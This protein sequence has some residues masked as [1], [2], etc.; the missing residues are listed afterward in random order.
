MRRTGAAPGS[1]ATS[2]TLW[3]CDLGL[4][5]ARGLE[6]PG[7]GEVR[8]VVAAAEV[9][10]V[11]EAM[12]A[13]GDLV[14]LRLRRGCRC[15]A[16]WEGGTVLGYAWLSAGPEWIGEVGLEIRPGPAE[17]YIWNCVTLPPHRLRGVFRSLV[18]AIC[19]QARSEGLRRLWIASLLGT[20]ERALRPPGF[21][22]AVRIRRRG[23]DLDLEPGADVLVRDGLS[24]LGIDRGVPLR[25]G[26]PRRH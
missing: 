26:R 16:A 12:G 3:A 14:A 5:R 4:Q 9:R 18:A 7:A 8:E 23:E 15:F 10:S 6:G 22:P 2:L 19:E 13:D 25:A 24:V 11:A 20:A 1:P 17:A 21:E